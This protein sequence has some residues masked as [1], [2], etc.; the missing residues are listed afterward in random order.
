MGDLKLTPEQRAVLELLADGH[1]PKKAAAILGCSRQA[2]I[3]RL[4]RARRAIG[5]RTGFQAVALFASEKI[6]GEI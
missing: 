4:D 2:V 5:A 3:N 6:K 1:K